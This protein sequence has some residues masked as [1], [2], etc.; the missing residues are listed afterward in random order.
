MSLGKLHLSADLSQDN[1]TLLGK[2]ISSLI[3]GLCPLLHHLPRLG[4]VSL[5]PLLKE[6]QAV[7]AAVKVTLNKPCAPGC[8][9]H[10]G[11]PGSS[12]V[13]PGPMA[14]D[15]DCSALMLALDYP[16]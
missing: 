8:L 14:I 15:V 7:V 10:P 16:G 11:S 1:I 6:L 13:P 2:I 5:H 9:G 3:C 4:R 12:A